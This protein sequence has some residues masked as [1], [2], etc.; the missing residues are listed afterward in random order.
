VDVTGIRRRLPEVK[1]A[2]Q[3]NILAV[4]VSNDFDWWPNLFDY[5]WLSSE[6]LGTFVGKLDNVLS[7]AREVTVGFDILTLLCFQ[8]GL[9][10]HLAEAIM[11]ILVDLSVRLLLGIELLWLLCQF[12][13]GDLP[14]DK[15]EVLGIGVTELVLLV[16]GGSDVCLVSKLEL[17]F[18]IIETFGRFLCG[19]VF[20]FLPRS[21]WRR[22]N[23][24]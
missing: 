18:H 24:L 13:Y 9:Q 8:Q 7:L 19:S 23:L 6:D 21:F 11:W 16:G 3:V 10:E 2:H 4:K 17:P 5:Y 20:W 1:E 15:R 14:D 12:V 22:L